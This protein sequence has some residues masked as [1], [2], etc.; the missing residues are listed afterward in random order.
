MKRLGKL[1]LCALAFWGILL[2]GCGEGPMEKKDTGGVFAFCG[3]ELQDFAETFDENE[4]AYMEYRDIID[5]PISC[6]IA[7]K[8]TIK[9]IFDALCEVRVG[10]KSNIRATDSEQSLTFVKEDGTSYVICFEQYHLWRGKNVYRLENDG[11]L[12]KALREAK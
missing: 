9:A 7:D 5:T 4:I 1:L 2:A 8:T 12:W 11:A 10:E 6:R 3:G